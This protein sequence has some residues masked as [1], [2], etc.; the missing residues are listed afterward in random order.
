[1]PFLSTALPPVAAT[2][3]EPVFVI[4]K[5]PGPTAAISR[6]FPVEWIVA[7]LVML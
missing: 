7:A 1:M 2:V 3:M 4:V 5:S 6:P